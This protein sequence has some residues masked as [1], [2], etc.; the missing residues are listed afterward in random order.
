MKKHLPEGTQ[1]NSPPKDGLS[2][3]IARGAG[4]Y[5]VISTVEIA[6]ASSRSS[7]SWP[8]IRK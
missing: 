1:A 3:W 4:D 2:G 8:L 7:M 6:S 5:S